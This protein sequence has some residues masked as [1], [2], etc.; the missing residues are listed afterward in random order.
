MDLPYTEVTAE[1]FELLGNCKKINSD[2][3]KII[4]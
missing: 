4:C 3:K 2:E 1:F